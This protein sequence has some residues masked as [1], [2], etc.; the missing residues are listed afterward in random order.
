MSTKTLRKRIAL[1]AVSAMGFGL[2]SAAPSSA[3]VDEAGV[4]YITAI[5]L[6][7]TSATSSG[8]NN[9]VT[10]TATATF[11]I[12]AAPGTGDTQ[13]I[14]FRGALISTPSNGAV[15]VAMANGT[16]PTADAGTAVAQAASGNKHTFTYAATTALT[17]AKTGTFL[18]KFTPTVA[19]TYVLRVWQD[20]RAAD[21]V[22]DAV[23][24]TVETYQDI[25]VTVGAAGALLADQIPNSADTTAGD[26]SLGGVKVSKVG[27]EVVQTSGRTGIQVGFAPQYLL[28]R[29]AGSITANDE[30]SDMSGKYATIAY[31]VTNPAGTAV[32]VYSAQGGT[33]ASASQAVAGLA[34]PG[35]TSATADIA[36]S[37]TISPTTGWP[38]KGSIVYFSAATAGTYTITAFHDAN[39]DTLVSVG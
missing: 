26:N 8:I 39:L 22:G 33:T 30:A 23:Y 21:G 17:A 18:A 25:T 19:G 38:Q 16:V 13:T 7:K 28:T 29:N 5:S 35:L 27:V 9:E 12:Q 36:R 37:Q 2:M 15:S 34:T 10:V 24:V 20:A 32:T 6:A 4:G 3:A 11:P 1:V 14:E 31:S